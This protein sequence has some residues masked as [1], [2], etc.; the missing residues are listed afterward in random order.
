MKATR[1]MKQFAMVWPMVISVVLE[2]FPDVFGG[3]LSQID[4]TGP[5]APVTM[6]T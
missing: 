2:V 3:E 1:P 6:A 4:Q 5:I